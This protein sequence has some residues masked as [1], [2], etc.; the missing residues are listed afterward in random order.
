MPE[1]IQNFTSGM[2]MDNS[3]LYQPKNSYIEA[4]NVELLSDALQGS[5]AISNSKG[6]KF[7]VTIPNVGNIFK[8]SF[9]ANGSSTI[10]INS[11]TSATSFVLTSASTYLDLYNFI[12][13]DPNFNLSN[14]SI[15]YNNTR[16]ILVPKPSTSL[17]VTVSNGT[18]LVGGTTPYIPAQSDLQAIGYSIIHNDIYI[19]TTNCKDQDPQTTGNGWGQIWKFN[20]DNINYDLSATSIILIYSGNLAFT[21]YYNI[22]QTGQVPRYE[23]RGIQR[24]YWTDFYNKVRSINIV[25]PMIFAEDVSLLDLQPIVNFDIPILTDIR[26]GG[27]SSA[28]GVYQVA[29]RLKNIGGSV[30]N[31]SNLSNMVYLVPHDE[32]AS[33][34]G[35]N[36]A[37]YIGGNFGTTDSK[38]MTFKIKNLDI[39][40]DEI[41][42]ALLFR[43]TLNSTPVVNIIYDESLNGNDSFTFVYDGTQTLTPISYGD[44]L[45]L[46]TSVTH[47]KTLATKDNRLILGNIKTGGAG[48][49]GA[50]DINFDAR[51]YRWDI[52]GTGF[53]IINNN[54]LSGILT[55]VDYPNIVDTNDAINPSYIDSSDPN[56]INGYFYRPD[57]NFGGQGPNIS[58]E[59]YTVDISADRNAGPTDFEVVDNQSAPW[60]STN[61]RY[62]LIPGV[63]LNLNVFSITNLNQPDL[64]VYNT[65][66]PNPINDGFKYPPI[67][68]LYKG[69][70]RNEIYRF[71]IEFY[72][73]DGNPF[74]VKWIGD[75]KFPDFADVNINAFY[76][77]GTIAPHADFRLSHVATK[78]GISYKEAFVRS[79]GISFTVNIP[80]NIKSLISG[81]SIVRVK[82]DKSDR[83]IVSEG[84]TC[85]SNFADYGGMDNQIYIT[86]VYTTDNAE[87]PS[88][89]TSDGSTDAH[90][91]FFITPDFCDGSNTITPS[92][93]ML[94]KVKALLTNANSDFLMSIGGSDPYGYNKLYNWTNA[95]QTPI[96]ITDIAFLN[97]GSQINLGGY[98]I[99]NYDFDPITPNDTTSQS[100]G[101]S[102]YYYILDGGTGG[103]DYTSITNGKFLVTIERTLTTQY[104]GN[105]YMDRSNNQYISCNH[106]QP[107]RIASP[108]SFTFE[109]FAGDIYL[110]MYDSCRWAKNWGVTGRGISTKGKG[111]TTLFL[112]IEA[113]INTDLRNGYYMNKDFTNRFDT[114]IQMVE[115]YRYNNVYSAENTS[116]LYYP[117]PDPFILNNEFDNRFYISDIKINGELTDSWTII[118]ENNYWDVEGTYGPINS[119]LIMN[120]KLYFWQDRAFGIMEVNPR[121]IVQDINATT[122]QIGT[123]LPLQ[124]HDYISTTVGSKHQGSTIYSDRKL[125]FYDTNTKK[126]YTFSEEELN[127]FSDIKGMYSYLSTNLNGEIQNVDKPVYINSMIGVNGVSATYDYKRH[128]VIFTFNS[129]IND[130]RSY[131]QTSF[132]LAINELNDTFLG[133]YSFTPRIYINDFKYIFSTDITL[134]TTLKNIYIHDVGNYGTYYGTIYNSYI[135]FIV[136]E[137]S[138]Y[139][140][141]FDNLVWDSETRN[142]IINMNND[143]WNSIRITNDYQNTDVIPLVYDSNIKRKERNWQLSVPRNRVLYTSTNSPNIYT[144]LSIGPKPFAE[145]MRDKYASIE[146][147]YNNTSNYQ[148]L[149]NNI[150]TLF[151]QSIR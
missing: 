61:P 50:G 13:N 22:P 137:D 82:R 31:F 7:Q 134:N 111:S 43:D 56:Y 67:N 89:N 127:P 123:G 1:S 121:A 138:Q 142:G 26:S 53:Q 40:F 106:Y 85:R 116:I 30:T 141:I 51:A 35:N 88:G 128:K 118:K 84:Y 47:A 133:F 146:L 129:G 73:A 44:F 55:A 126:I 21:T 70:Q 66:F 19:F 78:T 109:L 46:S 148:L 3:P 60:R 48:F 96:L 101:S 98:T 143:T 77:D 87:D 122:L 100:I 36:F 99:N 130:N 108:N 117:K 76:E 83:T 58:Y 110:N 81:Y 63:D 16:V 64:Q 119:S 125:Y 32:S 27:S 2:N 37:G 104:G 14:I 24:I 28:I 38:Q 74:F 120:D 34:F 75:I 18:V 107:V 147:T 12:L 136:N 23:N 68:S 69:Y 95:I 91:G 113:V 135:K 93:G 103:I 49:I 52:T 124:R 97:Y 132:T 144:D 10:T 6:N 140:K 54:A 151:R 41:E 86:S 105:K 79:L 149:T 139:R 9:L 114:G 102:C 145:R 5:I 62:E 42:I 33:S 59:F 80:V 29:Y 25:N 15:Y 39:N 71:G 17:T 150:R 45:L 65:R 92:S 112:P 72:D 4:I 90:K 115:D 11:I 20:Y 131:I 8:L 57:T 94:M